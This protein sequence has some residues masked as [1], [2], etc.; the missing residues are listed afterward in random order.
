[1]FDVGNVGNGS[2]ASTFY[3]DDEVQTATL[4]SE[5]IFDDSS[6]SVFPNPTNGILQIRS[7]NVELS[8]VELYSMLGQKLKEKNTKK[9]VFMMIRPPLQN[10]FLGGLW[11]TKS[12]NF[13][14]VA[15]SETKW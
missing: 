8:K 1:M 5:E 11:N 4:S 12:Q 2:A 6:I 9:N 13:Q 7:G 14:G 15:P 3:F 10:S